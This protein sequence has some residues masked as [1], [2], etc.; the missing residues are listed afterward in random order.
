MDAKEIQDV[1]IHGD[2]L[3]IMSSFSDASFDSVITDPPYNLSF[4]YNEYKDHLPWAEY[5]SWQ[6]EIAKEAARLLKPGGSFLWL[7]YPE[8]AAQMWGKMLEEVPELSPVKWL[9]WVYHQHTGGKPLRR[10]TRAWLWFAKGDPYVDTE[11]VAGEYRNP[12]DKRIRG[13]VE[14]GFL[15][16]D[17]D[18]WFYEQVKNVSAEKTAHPCQLPLAMVIRLVQMVTP[19]GG[20]VLDPFSGSG[21][22]PV[23]A[24]KLGRHYVG[25]EKDELYVKMSRERL[26]AVS[27]DL[28]DDC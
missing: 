23:A 7:N 26:M 13:R 12:N 6:V 21:T 3:Y 11:A 22:T 9:T 8:V 27:G 18:W 28:T 24:K 5:F 1:I 2:A 19:V 15:P 4:S 16:V 25:I 17:Y 14:Q 10:A 20:V